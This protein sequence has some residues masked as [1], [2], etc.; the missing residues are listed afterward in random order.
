[1]RSTR[2]LTFRAKQGQRALRRATP[3]VGQA[4][5]G[6]PGG[7]AAGEPRGPRPERSGAEPALRAGARTGAPPPLPP[8]LRDPRGPFS[9]PRGAER[10][11]G[12]TALCP[13]LPRPV[14]GETEGRDPLTAPVPRV[15]SRLRSGGAARPGCCERGGGES[16]RRSAHRRYFPSLPGAVGVET[17]Y[18]MSGRCR[19]KPAA[20]G[21]GRG[22]V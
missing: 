17:S 8:A 5:P 3:H 4:R 18:N 11:V 22:L 19:T 21:A 10:D 16:R 12:G 14:P 1:M 15:G 9:T 6:A 2:K 7:S 13:A 20:L